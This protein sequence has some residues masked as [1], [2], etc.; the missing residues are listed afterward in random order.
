VAR[1]RESFAAG[2]GNGT[3]QIE[4]GSTPHQ[5]VTDQPNV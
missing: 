4:R 2:S 3:G 1:D 5:K